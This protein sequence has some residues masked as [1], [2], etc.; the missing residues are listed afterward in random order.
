MGD[1]RAEEGPNTAWNDSLLTRLLEDAVED[2]LFA[3]RDI[4]AS[5]SVTCER[6]ST[7][8]GP[9][10]AGTRYPDCCVPM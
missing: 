5:G 3:C 4:W 9:E 6:V 10:T 8:L 7:L 1:A 2:M